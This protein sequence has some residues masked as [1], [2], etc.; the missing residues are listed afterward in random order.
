MKFNINK[1]KDSIKK[2]D[3]QKIKEMKLEDIKDFLQAYKNKVILSVFLPLII[4]FFLYIISLLLTVKDN[5]N[6]IQT[7]VKE[8]KKITD[9]NIL[10][11]IKSNKLRSIY[12]I[13]STAHMINKKYSTKDYEETLWKL[14][15]LLMYKDTSWNYRN[16]IDWELFR[17]MKDESTENKINLLLE[18]NNSQL[19]LKDFTHSDYVNRYLS[20]LIWKNL[21]LWEYKNNF[22]QNKTKVL[23]STM[24][25]LYIYELI[26]I[27][28]NLKNQ[29]L[30]YKQI[31]YKYRYPYTKFLSYIL[32]PSV[33]IW[34]NN[35]S[36]KINIDIFWNKYIKKAD[37]MD[38]NLIKY[39]SNYFTKAYKWKL[40]QWSKNNID[41]IWVWK[42]NILKNNFATL[43]ITI[44][45][46]LSNERSFYWLI[47]KLTSTSNKKNIMNIDEFT[48]YLWN[49]VKN[50]ITSL[51]KSY[52]EQGFKSSKN[53]KIWKKYISALVYKCLKD[54]ESFKQLNC[55][56]IF[57]CSN[58]K[59]NNNKIKCAVEDFPSYDTLSWYNY[60]DFKSILLQNK[61]YILENSF[62]YRYNRNGYENIDSIDTL[63][64]ARLYDCLINDDYCT[65]LF[66]K[67]T[68]K[69]YLI[70]KTI[71]DFAR[72]DSFSDNR[73]KSKFI[74]K[75]DTNYFIA[76]TMVEG[77]SGKNK[78][79]YTYLDR[80]KDVYKNISWFIKIWKF[81]FNKTDNALIS[82]NDIRY[83][84]TSSLKVYYKYISD[85]DIKD[86]L[87]FIWK[88]KC[89]SVTN[90]KAWSLDIASSY[91]K[92]IKDNL[93]N[94]NKSAW[95]VYELDKTLS[96]LDWLKKDY[97]K[98]SN[99]DKILLALQAYRILK[100]RWDCSR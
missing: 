36:W 10:K 44:N 27:E 65:D 7:N 29:Y 70:K 81:T 83:K 23:L 54:E 59:I 82:A 91:I 63:L 90:W 24:K 68:D 16:R 74:K 50:N 13:A 48:Y 56:K 71:K 19:N 15:V 41:N 66:I 100:E 21:S 92:W 99:L 75:F 45:F 2:L 80:L 89:S 26:F 62:V 1:I 6:K 47:S 9:T 79:I 51:I 4:I 33:N 12:T 25:N 85:N 3:M 60:N 37:F 69:F 40:Y 18:K 8:I 97:A 42:F 31:Y 32:L 78:L 67:G 14:I 39:W 77:L 17:E 55:W 57:G 46:S 61:K 52:D 64:W 94:T 72:C 95:E 11:S 58:K 73:C 86:I 88:N 43:P 84:A 49:N 93:Y 22:D 28:E 87:N 53:D 96:I 20:L 5:Y 34:K 30:K 98:K 35:F 38:L 76:Y